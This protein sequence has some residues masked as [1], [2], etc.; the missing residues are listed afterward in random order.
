MKNNNMQRGGFQN[1][2]QRNGPNM[3]GSP[4]PNG[5]RNMMNMSGGQFRAPGNNQK[6]KTVQCKYFE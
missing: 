3:R 5:Q 2:G 1:K 4:N 6:Y